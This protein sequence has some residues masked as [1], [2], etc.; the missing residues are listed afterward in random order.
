MYSVARRD[1]IYCLAVIR[2]ELLSWMFWERVCLDLS[3]VLNCG[4]GYY[5][6]GV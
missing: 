3:S 2:R 5:G 1:F 6:G 4:C